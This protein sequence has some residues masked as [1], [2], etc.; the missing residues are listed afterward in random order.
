MENAIHKNYV[1]LPSCKP[2]LIKFCQL[3]E[4]CSSEVVE[5]KFMPHR[6]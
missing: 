6:Y 1:Q 2:D 3:Y 5:D 4:N